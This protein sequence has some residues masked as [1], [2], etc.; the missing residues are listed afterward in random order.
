MNSQHAGKQ[1]KALT[2]LKPPTSLSFLLGLLRE[3]PS[4]DP[5]IE[6]VLLGWARLAGRF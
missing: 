5:L 1:G 4:V 2:I 3:V 6:G